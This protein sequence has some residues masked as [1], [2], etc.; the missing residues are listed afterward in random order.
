[1]KE[2]RKNWGQTN[3]AINIP[4][5]KQ[6]LKIKKVL[7]ILKFGKINKQDYFEPQVR[8]ILYNASPKS[9]YYD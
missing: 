6:A 2:M 3:S 5:F 4:I 8:S 7:K 9:K 1:M